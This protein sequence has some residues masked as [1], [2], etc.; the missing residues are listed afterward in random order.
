MVESNYTVNYL[1][2]SGKLKVIITERGRGEVVAMCLYIHY[3]WIVINL[4]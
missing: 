2:D 1:G 3:T 4:M